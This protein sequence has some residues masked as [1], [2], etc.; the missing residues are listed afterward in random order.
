MSNPPIAFEADPLLHANPA[1]ALLS[2]GNNN[3]LTASAA[4]APDDS[5]RSEMESESGATT[6]SSAGEPPPIHSYQHPQ[7]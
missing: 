3:N 5:D 4:D 7:R 1:L 2:R 6:A